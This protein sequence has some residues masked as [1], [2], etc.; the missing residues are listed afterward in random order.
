MTRD[1]AIRSETGLCTTPAPPPALLTSI[2]DDHAGTVVLLDGELDLS[3]SPGLYREL[4]RLI[5]RRPPAV[6]L[7]LERLTF[8]DSTGVSVLNTVRDHAL[9]HEVVFGLR[10]PSRAVA[11][12]LEVTAMWELFDTTSNRFE[13]ERFVW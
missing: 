4:E 8:I 13:D 7:D 12:V 9:R 11:R 2:V 6:T 3:T 5:A 1:L 10:S